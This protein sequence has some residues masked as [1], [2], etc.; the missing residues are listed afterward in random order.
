[1]KSHP[2]SPEQVPFRGTHLRFVEPSCVQALKNP[3]PFK[4]VEASVVLDV[5]VLV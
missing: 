3:N 2:N 4:D 5:A 1:L